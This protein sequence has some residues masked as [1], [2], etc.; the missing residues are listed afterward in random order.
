MITVTPPV[1][2]I[3]RRQAT[4]TGCK[5]TLHFDSSDTHTAPSRPGD[6]ASDRFVTCPKCSTYVF[7]GPG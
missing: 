2:K 7:V 5:S 1:V 6:N 3:E 4:C